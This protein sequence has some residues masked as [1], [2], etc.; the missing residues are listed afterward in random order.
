MSK[1]GIAISRV[2]FMRRL[3]RAGGG[4]ARSAAGPAPRPRPGLRPVP[5]NAGRAVRFLELAAWV[6]CG[7]CLPAGPVEVE[8]QALNGR[9]LRR[10]CACAYPANGR[11]QCWRRGSGAGR[12]G[13]CDQKMTEISSPLKNCGYE[14]LPKTRGELILDGEF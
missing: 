3:L 12:E 2:S 6:H 8:V 11:A 5:R 4:P 9:V 1:S 14:Y 10:N 13:V 7:V